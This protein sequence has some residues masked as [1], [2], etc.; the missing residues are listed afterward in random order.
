MTARHRTLALIG[1]ALSLVG[2]AAGCD[3]SSRGGQDDGPGRALGGGTGGVGGAHGAAAGGMTAGK[4]STSASGGQAGRGGGTGGTTTPK[5]GRGGAPGTGGSGASAG[6]DAGEGGMETDGTG[7][8]ARAGRGGAAAG[9]SAGASPGGDG[10]LGA[11]CASD[12]H[13]APYLGCVTRTS[14]VLD[15]KSPAGGLCTLPCESDADCRVAAAGA[16]CVAFGADASA[17]FCLEGCRPGFAGEPKCH[18]RTDLACTLLGLKP[19][20]TACESSDDCARTEVCATGEDPAVCGEIV[21]GCAPNCGGDFDCAPGNF[22]DFATGLCAPDEPA[23]QPIG[24][25]CDPNAASD[26]CNGFCR[27]KDDSGTEGVCAA[28]CTL[29]PRLHGCGWDGS[30][31]ADA[32]CLYRTRLSPDAGIGDVGI[33]GALCDCNA[34]CAAPDDRC[35]DESNGAIMSLWGRAGYCR[36]LETGESVA[37]TFERCP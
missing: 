1:A 5:G 4:G 15:G 31:P 27:T 18:E 14:G 11:S 20:D 32:A 17:T 25:L 34:D 29:S 21:T 3:S 28:F 23:G 26:P 16:L 6:L 30:A 7:G 35:M 37:D 9:G 22:C 24:A 2:T 12:L 10:S 19:T 36:P 13:C 8:T 33:C